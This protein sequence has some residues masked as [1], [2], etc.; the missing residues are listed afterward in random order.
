MRRP[1]ATT[2]S[3]SISAEFHDLV[4]PA[5][6]ATEPSALACFLQASSTVL[7]AFTS[8]RSDSALLVNPLL[9]ADV[10][11]SILDG[12]LLLPSMS[13]S[14]SNMSNVSSRRHLVSVIRGCSRVTRIGEE[15]TRDLQLHNFDVTT[16]M[17]INQRKHSDPSSTGVGVVPVMFPTHVLPVHLERL[18]SSDDSIATLV[19]QADVFPAVPVTSKSPKPTLAFNVVQNILASTSG[20]FIPEPPRTKFTDDFDEMFSAAP[21][22]LHDQ[23]DSVEILPQCSAMDKSNVITEGDSH[24]TEEDVS[25][26]SYHPV[27]SVSQQN[28]NITLCNPSCAG[29]EAEI[30]ISPVY[31]SGLPYRPFTLAC[32]H[33]LSAGMNIMVTVLP[34]LIASNR[35]HDYSTWYLMQMYVSV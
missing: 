11:H 21:H 10:S 33:A 5:T 16:L 34:W 2:S 6:L 35:L 32:S 12:L 25:A 29:A 8:L 19:T 18:I 24:T 20:W 22:S 31:F 17:Q 4:R 30:I 15:D 13:H 23:V 3:R 9:H 7:I 28:L 26:L 14:T 1:S 27:I